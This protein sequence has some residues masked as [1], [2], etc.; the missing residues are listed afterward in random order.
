[1][2]R[3][4]VTDARKQRLYASWWSAALLKLFTDTHFTVPEIRV[5]LK[6]PGSSFFLGDKYGEAASYPQLQCPRFLLLSTLTDQ[7]W[8]LPLPFTRFPASGRARV[9]S[10]CPH[11]D[12][13]RGEWLLSTAVS[14]HLGLFWFADA[15]HS[16]IP[17]S[18]H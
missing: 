9:P 7:H 2:I 3:V 13:R 1:M 17:K 4:L 14:V 16:G 12:T 18:H 15:G 8:L 10:R 5:C 6:I 11:S